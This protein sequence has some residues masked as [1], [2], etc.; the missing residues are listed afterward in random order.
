M[1]QCHGKDKAATSAMPN[2]AKATATSSA[3]PNH[4]KGTATASAMPNHL[5]GTATASAMRPKQVFADENI[6][7]EPLAHPHRIRQRGLNRVPSSVLS[8]KHLGK[9]RSHKLKEK[10][11]TGLIPHKHNAK[12]KMCPPDQLR[13]HIQGIQQPVKTESRLAREMSQKLR[14][15]VDTGSN[16]QKHNAKEKTCASDQDMWPFKTEACLAGEMSQRR[17][18][19]VDTGSNQQKHSAEK[20]M[21]PPDQL[22]PHTHGIQRKERLSVE[23]KHTKSNTSFP[24]K[25]TSPQLRTRTNSRC[26]DAGTSRPIDA[27][28]H[29]NTAAIQEQKQQ[30]AATQVDEDVG[31]IIQ[32]LNELGLGEDIDFE[33]YYGYLQQ[34]P[35]DRHVDTKT[36]L[37]LEDHF[38]MDL[39]HAVYRIRSYKLLKKESKNELCCDELKECPMELL[40]REEFPTDFLVKMRYFSFF[41]NEGIL[42][43][44][45][46]PDLYKLACVNDYQRLVPRK[47]SAYE[48]AGWVV[49]RGYLHSYEMQYEYIEY[50][51]TLL[52]ELKWLK[53]CLPSKFSSLSV[54]KIRTRGIYQATKIAT[55]FSKITTHLARIGFRDCFNYMCIEATWCNGS[56]GLYFEIWKRV[57]QQKESFRDSLKEV[58]KLNKCPSLQDSIKYAM[59]HDCSVMETA[60]LRCTV[61]AGITNEVPEDK[62]QELIA[63]AVEK[64]RIKPKF[65]DGYI[66]KKI[67]IAKAIGMITE[68]SSTDTLKDDYKLNKCPSFQ[69]SIKY[70][71]E[72]DCSVREWTVSE[73]KGQELI[74]EAVKKLRIKPEFCDDIREKIEIAKPV[75]MITVE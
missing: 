47:H 70:A 54:S 11:D 55:R 17:M 48:Y 53:D 51:E 59:E 32:K 52:R 42:D 69:H 72:E 28:D 37:N 24:A 19:K 7:Q 57:T 75:G 49:Y 60:F 34:L 14:E 15:K 12:V 66:R 10:V 1:Q 3:M 65:Y 30:Y 64:L 46:D 38:N 56:D 36:E 5:K 41:D 16:P 18:E 73:D 74:A 67:D 62:A 13:H 22:H 45:F 33:E 40:D 26:S 21:C 27:H 71:L 31:D 4:A 9:E 35:P 68:D 43:W 44:F 25:R 50:F 29:G 8:R 23:K 58:Y 6:V 20:K 63:E 61:G 2:Y 39:R